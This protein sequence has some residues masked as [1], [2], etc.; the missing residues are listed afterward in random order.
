MPNPLTKDDSARIQSTQARGGGD[1][2]SG[3]F[4]ARAQAAGDR[5]ANMA[6]TNPESSYSSSR[7]SNTGAAGS[8]GSYQ[9]SGTGK[10]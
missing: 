4:A 5:Y 2:S 9:H 3:G 8:G 10:R 7:S 6:N 1:M